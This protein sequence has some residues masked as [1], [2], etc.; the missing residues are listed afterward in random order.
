[1][2]R[3]LN[4]LTQNVGVRGAAAVTRD[5]MVVASALSGELDQDALAAVGAALAEH[6][7]RA[8]NALHVTQVDRLI[9]VG[10]RGKIIL[11]DAEVAFLVVVTDLGINLDLTLLDIAAAA[12]KLRKAAQVEV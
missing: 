12:Y 3:L 8:L 6:A 10:S 1:V 7:I 4:E 2:R 9:I 11:V 5:G